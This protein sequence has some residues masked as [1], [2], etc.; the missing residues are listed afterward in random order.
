MKREWQLTKRLFPVA[1]TCEHT[2]I[3]HFFLVDRKSL[4]ID[5]EYLRLVRLARS[6]SQDTVLKDLLAVIDSSL[7][8][9]V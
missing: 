9:M 3:Q 4:P 7:K 8:K 1:P 2:K 5:D 6:R